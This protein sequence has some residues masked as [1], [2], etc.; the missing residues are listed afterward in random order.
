MTWPGLKQDVERLCSTCPVCPLIKKDRACN[1]YGLLPLK[2]A[3]SDH[4][5]MFCVDL[6]GPFTMKTPY[7]THSH[8]LCL[9]SL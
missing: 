4:W 9:L 2:V 5:V 3:E 1:K 8:T 7:K 6:A